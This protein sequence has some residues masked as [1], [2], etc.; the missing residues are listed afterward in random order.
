MIA[1]IF[2]VWPKPEHRQTYFDLAADLKPI[3]QTI[4]GFISVERFESLTEKGKIL[5]V[6]FWRDEAAVQAWR[7]TMEHR[8]TQA[9][10]RAQICRLSSAHRQRH[11]G[12]RHERSR[13]GAEGQS[14]RA[15][16]ALALP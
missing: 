8:R 2:E 4:D 13:R 6:S 15:R 5:S 9:K 1:V 10:G 3:L 11:Q 16:C 12:L 14:R 7:N